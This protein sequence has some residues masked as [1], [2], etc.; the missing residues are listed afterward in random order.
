MSYSVYSMLTVLRI[1]K[2]LEMLYAAKEALYIEEF[3]I[4]TCVVLARI[5]SACFLL[6]DHVVW[7]H[8][9]KAI[10]IDI[11]PISRLSNRFWL[12]STVLSLMRNMYDWHRIYQ[13]NSLEG[14]RAVGSGYVPQ[15]IPT[16]LDTARNAF[17]ILIPMNGL[18]YASVPGVVQGATGTLSSLIGILT[19]WNDELKLQ[20][21]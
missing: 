12:L 3:I 7:M 4:Q 17:D 19:L 14:K 18:Q 9:V 21:K 13:H 5:S 8:R 10:N 15:T 2:S 11:K 20:N 1:G 6:L 16:L